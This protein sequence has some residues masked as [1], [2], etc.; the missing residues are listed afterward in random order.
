M[1]SPVDEAAAAP[2]PWSGGP[3]ELDQVVPPSGNMWLAGSLAGPGAGG[4]NRAVLGEHPGDPSIDRRRRVK[5]VAS[6]QTVADLPKLAVGG[7]RRRSS[8]TTAMST[9]SAGPRHSI[10]YAKHPATS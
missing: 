5:S 10:G 9:P 3:V 1:G 4:A 7:L 6:H 2:D 8:S